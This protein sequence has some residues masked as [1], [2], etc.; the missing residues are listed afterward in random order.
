MQGI[1]ETERLFL[2]KMTMGIAFYTSIDVFYNTTH[3]FS[4][5]DM[6]SGDLFGSS[7]RVL[8]QM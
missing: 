4:D 2:R 6:C 7:G 1:L 5:S 8:Y 3:L